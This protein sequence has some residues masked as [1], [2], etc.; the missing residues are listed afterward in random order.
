MIFTLI[1]YGGYIRCSLTINGRNWFRV[2]VETEDMKRLLIA[3]VIGMV[4]IVGLFGVERIRLWRAKSS[5][6]SYR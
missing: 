1:E 5:R 3:L 4:V 6:A 2:M